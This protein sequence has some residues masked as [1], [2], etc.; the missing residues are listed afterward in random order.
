[1]PSK[2]ILVVLIVCFGIVGAIW[3]LQENFGGTPAQL[4]VDQ[5]TSVES[6]TSQNGVV[7]STNINWQKI[8]GTVQSTTTIVS[9]LKSTSVAL[10]DDTMTAQLA[11]D[12]FGRYLLAQGQATQ[13]GADTTGGLDTGT[14]DQIVSGVLSS[15]GYTTAQA[16]VYTAQNLNIRPDSN[17]TTVQNYINSLVQYSQQMSNADNKN[18]NEVDI[19]NNAI[20]NQDQNEI[21][22]LDPIIKSYQ[23]LLSS[24]LKIPVPKEATSLHLKFVNSVSKILSDLQAIRQ[25]FVDP[26]KSLAALGTYQQDFTDMGLNIQNLETYAQIKLK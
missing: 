3:I 13:S 15:D 26:V 10:G 9:S 11:K 4:A 19:I 23:T 22:K 18:G 21:A 20:L 5:N 1:M 12:F 14:S 16:V 25:T 24:V 2:K 7:T 17:K 6:S 8:L